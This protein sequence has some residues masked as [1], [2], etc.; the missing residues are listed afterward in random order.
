[1]S[2]LLPH[3]IDDPA[4]QAL[5]DADRELVT[6]IEAH[7]RDLD[8]ARAK[9]DLLQDLM[10]RLAK[11]SQTP[12]RRIERPNPAPAPE[13]PAESLVTE[14]P[15]TVSV[16]APIADSAVVEDECSRTNA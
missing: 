13:T 12:R 15:A 11:K 5:R 4:M 1:M 10:K 8:I 14:A 2:E 6:E 9:R 16:F 7:Q 3:L